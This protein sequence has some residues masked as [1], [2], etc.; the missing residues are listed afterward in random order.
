MP[1][2][3]ESKRILIFRPAGLGDALVTLPFFH[4]IARRFPQADKRVL[5]TLPPGAMF[6]SL[7]SILDGSGLVQGYFEVDFHRARH[8]LR[9]QLA[10][11]KLIRSWRPEFAIY[12]VAPRTLPRLLSEA[13]FFRL[14]GIRRIVG[15]R[16]TRS[17]Q[18]YRWISG[19]QL[20]EHET[21]RIA[22]CVAELGD[23]ELG[24]P[25]SWNLRLT[26][27]E[28]AAAQTI[29][30]E[31]IGGRDFL[32]IATGTGMDANDWGEPNWLRF[33]Q[34]LAGVAGHYGLALVGARPDHPRSEAVRSAWPGPS[35]NLCGKFTP[36]ENAALMEMAT[37]FVGHD[38][39]PIHLAA[40]VGLR[41]V[42]IYG[43]RNMP[44]PWFPYGE[45]HRIVYHEVPCSGCGL[46][47]CV[48]YAKKCITS[49]TIEEALHA[50]TTQLA[51]VVR[52]GSNRAQPAR[53]S[54]FSSAG[55]R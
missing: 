39:G 5:C 12:L 21:E 6:A 55:P 50:T 54:E 28:R 41:C 13:M 23:P 11:R 52:I 24:N 27:S 29:V 10:L 33:T 16:F 51:S 34:R 45:G 7:R 49:I 3:D 4:L 8:N 35:V 9:D 17:F 2:L 22:R 48:R 15:A 20:F 36:R 43:G 40:T 26:P 19:K 18:E 42:G 32:V 38:S 46:A 44:G 47:E 25:A 14:C 53:A 37:L 30:R 1:S 31:A